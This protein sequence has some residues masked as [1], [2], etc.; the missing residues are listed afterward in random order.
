M[1]LLLQRILFILLALV[2]AV[3]RLP[4]VPVG[5]GE[6][7]LRL[8]GLFT[9][10]LGLTVYIL[11]IRYSLLSFFAASVIL[12]LYSAGDVSLLISASLALQI[13]SIAF[14]PVILVGIKIRRP[15]RFAYTFD[16]AVRY[17]VLFGIFNAVLAISSRL[18]GVDY[19]FAP[20]VYLACIGSYGVL[21]RPYLYAVVIGAALCISLARQ[22]PQL[23]AGGI[24]MLGLL[25]SDSRSIAAA[26]MVFAFIA[27]F[28]RAR[29]ATVR[30][31]LAALF[32]LAVII[33]STGEGKLSFRGQVGNEEVDP[34][35]QVRLANIEKYVDWVDPKRIFVGGGALAF[36][37][38]SVQY[39]VAGPADNL[40]VRLLS[41]I[42]I[43]GIMALL[44]PYWDSRLFRR[45]RAR[46][47]F[48]LYLLVALLLFISTYHE[49]L[50]IAKSGHSIV[51]LGMYIWLRIAPNMIADSDQEGHLSLH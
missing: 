12:I 40:Y 20:E 33:V 28:L 15:N 48:L 7:S 50:V 36:Y 31:T 45:T 42:G 27:G 32:L 35:W 21:D 4:L 11:L 18:V 9:F 46:S 8:D 24:L 47:S 26:F 17:F 5:L 6:L 3:P 16:K 14:L 1:D 43:F 2:L 25:I 22:K 38:F 30:G 23:V 19:C 39:S 41:E 49:S 51:L 29:T 13:I 34:S 44:A 37:E 10:L